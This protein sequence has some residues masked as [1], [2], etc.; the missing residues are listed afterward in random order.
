MPAGPEDPDGMLF[1]KYLQIILSRRWLILAATVVV[2][3][4]VAVWT[5]TRERIYASKVSMIVDRRAPR[6]LGGKVNEVINLG[7]N[8]SK[9]IPNQVALACSK[10][11]AE[12]VVG[13]MGLHRIDR[14]WPRPQ[15]GVTIQRTP[16]AAAGRLRGML[17]CASRT[18]ADIIDITAFHWD[19]KMAARV[20]NGVAHVFMDRNVE[21]KTKSTT[22]ALSW[23]KKE[24]GTLDNDLK[25]SELALYKFKQ[26]NNL[27]AVSL[28]DHKSIA[29]KQI[30]RVNNARVT[31]QLDRLAA[32]MELAQA[33]LGE[34]DPIKAAALPIFAQSPLIGGLRQRILSLQQKQTVLDERYLEDHPENKRNRAKL[35]SVNRDLRKEITNVI[36]AVRTTYKL[37][38]RHEGQLAGALEHAKKE[39][40]D[41][42]RSELAFKQL[43]RKTKHAEKIYA[44]VLTRM[45][46]SNLSKNVKANNIRLLD[47]AEASWAPVKPRVRLNLVVGGLLGLLL[48][49]GLAFLLAALDNTIKSLEDAEAVRN[50]VCLGFIPSIPNVHLTGKK[51]SARELNV[52]HA[53]TSVTSESCRSIRT[54]LMFASP[55]STVKQI[56]VTS[57]GPEEGKTTTAVSLAITMAQAGNR[58][59]IVDADMRRPQLHRVF[60]VPRYEGLSTAL[61]GEFPSQETIDSLIKTTEVPNLFV[62]PCGPTPPNPAELCQSERL[63]KVLDLLSDGFDWVVLD[64][65]PLLTVTDPVLLGTQADGAV[66]VAR[67]GQTPKASLHAAYRTLSDV[68]INVLGCVLND[69]DLAHHSYYRYL[70]YRYYAYGYYRS[71][72]ATQRESA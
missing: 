33:K 11:T 46:E 47:K 51:K 28:D 35:A 9:T 32:S 6:I 23:L 30:Q 18:D 45:K 19:P 2:L 8:S 53:P 55:D 5:Y 36:A 37:K 60:G 62:L 21:F 59:L 34:K 72:K 31:A 42:N 58:V 10:T 40:F 56:V 48:G 4:A 50:L 26:K 17:R 52:H 64:S 13:A 27:L 71:T 15:K 24:L 65:P 1:R 3:G 22:T 39:A 29:G 38:R 14:F 69:L 12:M 57:P 25:E 43:Q 7:Q 49:I 70:R 61:S 68:G 66:L 44:M 16:E 67:T 54:N 63:K 20:A 41:V